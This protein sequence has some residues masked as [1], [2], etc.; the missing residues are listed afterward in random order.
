VVSCSGPGVAPELVQE[1]GQPVWLGLAIGVSGTV[2]LVGES[3]TILST[4]TTQRLYGFT[5]AWVRELMQHG[6]AWW[7][8]QVER[9]PSLVPWESGQM[10]V[11]PGGK[12]WLEARG[13]LTW[14]CCQRRL[15]VQWHP[16]VLG[17]WMRNDTQVRSGLQGGKWVGG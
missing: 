15:L 8:F 2:L 3:I 16:T 7:A 10:S 13:A 9:F 1:E 5:A 12:R 17:T 11:L 14:P 4:I 6:E